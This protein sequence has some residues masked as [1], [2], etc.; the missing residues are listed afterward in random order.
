[1]HECMNLIVQYLR[2]LL[3]GLCRWQMQ[4]V[5]RYT[6]LVFEMFFKIILSCFTCASDLLQTC[7]WPALGQVHTTI[8]QEHAL[9]SCTIP[10][11]FPAVRFSAHSWTEIAPYHTRSS[12][13]TTFEICAA[14]NC[15]G[16]VEPCDL[17]PAN[18]LFWVPLTI[19]WHPQRITNAVLFEC[20]A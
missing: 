7:C 18:T 4:C 3:W 5:F 8:T 13:F 14:L 10:V 16:T 1:M 19:F 17:V 9:H 20:G 12:A 11:R 2:S 6:Q 15:I